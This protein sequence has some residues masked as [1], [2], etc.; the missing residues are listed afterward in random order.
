MFW[1]E[2]VNRIDK[3]FADLK[4]NKKTAFVA[5][6]TAG[7]VK[8]GEPIIETVKLMHSLVKGG[9]DIIELG[10]P[11]SDPSADGPTIQQSNERALSYD[12]SIED[13]MVMVEEFRRTN[14]KV[15]II[16]MGYLNPI[17]NFG[18]KEFTELANVAGVDGLITVDLPP[19]EA[20]E[21]NQYL[22]DFNILPIYLVAPTTTEKRIKIIT[23]QAKGFIYYVSVKGVTGSKKLDIADVKSHVAKIRQYTN[24]PIG[25]GFG[26][27]DRES[28][29]N[30]SEFADA[31]VVGSAIIDK[32]QST[33][34]NVKSELVKFI[35]E[36]CH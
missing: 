18:F 7:D 34:S 28:V 23:Q 20:F 22:A 36:L 10:V 17:E 32:I 25:I 29:Q 15:P 11:F 9:A 3:T 13:V 33:E 27:K 19:E 30:V 12:T 31:V 2:F 26:I 8:S 5:F 21:Y 4:T 6:I 24:L 1:G 35:S 14:K 16:L